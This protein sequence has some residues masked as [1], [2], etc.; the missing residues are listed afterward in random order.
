M[1]EECFLQ[2]ILQKFLFNISVARQKTG[3]KTIKKNKNKR[4]TLT[5]QVHVLLPGNAKAISLC[6]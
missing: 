5:P 2:S 4:A 3:T 6:S 1:A